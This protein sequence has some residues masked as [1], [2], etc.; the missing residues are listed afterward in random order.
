[1][2]LKVPQKDAKQ[3]I[4]YLWKIID[5]PEISKEDLIYNISFKFFLLS[6]SKASRLIQQSIQKGYLTQNQ[7]GTI[8][9]SD[10]LQKR[11]NSWQQKRRS[12]ILKQQKLKEKQAA[13]LKA[14]QQSKPSDF[15]TLLKAFLDKGTLNR[16]VRV[17]EDSFNFNTLNLEA[18][19][20]KGEV[21]GSKDEPYV[22]ELDKDKQLLK[23]DCQDFRERRAPNKKFCKHLAKLFFILQER[24][25]D[26]TI[27][28][29]NR[30][31]NTINDWEFTP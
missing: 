30:I 4:L 3:V 17:T 9:L 15:S 13:E 29:L 16:A 8:S 7:D 10:T 21:S 12:K 14:L 11:L 1:M 2:N 26:L 28:L 24:N 25:E 20:I 31:G 23:H 22:I 19:I 6:P 18:G 27:D 5:L